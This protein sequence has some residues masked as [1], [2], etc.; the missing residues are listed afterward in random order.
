MASKEQIKEAK[1]KVRKNLS[2]I[3]EVSEQ[4]ERAEIVELYK[5]IYLASPKTNK[6]MKKKGS[7]NFNIY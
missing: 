7:K 5:Q 4:D 1:K 3:R 2:P 6:R